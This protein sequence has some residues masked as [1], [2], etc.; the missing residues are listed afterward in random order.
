VYME[1]R[2][3][4]ILLPASEPVAYRLVM[5][6][7]FIGHIFRTLSLQLILSIRMSY[8]VVV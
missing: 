6:E 7:S 4:R 3:C 8:G 1:T 2:K 5:L